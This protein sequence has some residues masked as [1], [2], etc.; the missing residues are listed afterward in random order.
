MLINIYVLHPFQQLFIFILNK[1]INNL[2]FS[3][4]G[5]TIYILLTLYSQLS[6]SK[7]RK[8]YNFYSLHIFHKNR[9]I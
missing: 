2:L 7:T 3:S 4:H 5:V 9:A 8:N 1:F 6:L